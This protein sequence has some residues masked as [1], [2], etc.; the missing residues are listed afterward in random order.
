MG[1]CR[2]LSHVELED[3]HRL[4]AFFPTPSEAADSVISVHT[5]SGHFS[6]KSLYSNLISG[7]VASK[8]KDIWRPHI[9]QAIRGRLPAT[10]HFRKSNGQALEF[11]A[12]CAGLEDSDHILLSCDNKGRRCY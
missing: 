1:F 6:V 9:R 4:A 8:L 10:D 11:C 2:A 5:A 7:S 3:W 12:L